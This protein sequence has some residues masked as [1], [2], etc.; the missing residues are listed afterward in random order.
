[1]VD[2]GSAK[3]LEW[4]AKCTRFL[5]AGKITAEEFADS[6]LDQISGVSANI[7]FASTIVAAIPSDARPALAAVVRAALDPEF[8]KPAWFYGPDNREQTDRDAESAIRTQR[9]QRWAKALSGP[10]ADQTKPVRE[11]IESS[12]DFRD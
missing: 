3:L 10:L 12:D 2:D 6:L 4:I 9:L 11:M 1:V 5:V 7:E 8:R